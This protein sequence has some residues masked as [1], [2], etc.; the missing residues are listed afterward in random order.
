MNPI[1]GVVVGAV[2]GA[3][4]AGFGL[5]LGSSDDAAAVND[6][7]PITSTTAPAVPAAP[8]WVDP[9]EVLLGSSI[10]LPTELTLDG[11]ELTLDFEM[12]DLAPP[13]LGGDVD[14]STWPAFRQVPN[15]EFNLVAPIEWTLTTTAGEEI[16]G[17]T[18]NVRATTARFPVPDGFALTDVAEIRLD[19]Y[20]QRVPM[21]HDLDVRTNDLTAH[22]LDDTVSISLVDILEDADGTTYRFRID[23]DPAAFLA[24]GLLVGDDALLYGRGPGWVSFGINETTVQLTHE[25]DTPLDTVPIRVVTNAWLEIPRPQT[26]PIGGLTG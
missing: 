10:L 19:S 12:E 23:H 14:F 8:P 26:I 13:T 2:A 24:T 21:M 5:W 18:A 1:A 9:N 3:A 22:V 16:A 20:R 25:D 15:T 4:L 6:P 17:R 11:T 7:P